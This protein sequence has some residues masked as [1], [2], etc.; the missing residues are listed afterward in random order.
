MPAETA[1]ELNSAPDV[2]VP[3]HGG[4]FSQRQ[5][6]SRTNG[7]RKVGMTTPESCT[8][9]SKRRANATRSPKSEDS[10]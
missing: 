6:P 9:C 7:T 4:N 8:I 2:R 5:A 1:C 3:S 10:R